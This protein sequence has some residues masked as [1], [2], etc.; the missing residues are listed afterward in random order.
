M[1][2]P[3]FV[4]KNEML[5]LL[6]IQIDDLIS[7]RRSN[8]IVIYKKERIW[9]VLYFGVPADCREKIKENEKINEFLGFARKLKSCEK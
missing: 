2:K 9:R 1:H 3:K 6:K 4:E 7:I 8:V 5:K